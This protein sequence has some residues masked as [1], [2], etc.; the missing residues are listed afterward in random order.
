MFNNPLYSNTN[1]ILDD[2]SLDENEQANNYL[3]TKEEE[4][5]QRKS[6]FSTNL[7]TF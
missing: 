6:R 2:E 3:I 1:K 7:Q 5:N 4:E